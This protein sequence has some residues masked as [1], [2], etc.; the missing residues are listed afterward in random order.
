HDTARWRHRAEPRRFETTED[1]IPAAVVDQ[2]LNVG[3]APVWGK[4]W[5]AGHHSIS[6]IA[7]LRPEPTPMV[8]TRSP[9]L[10]E[11]SSRA[12][13]M[14]RAAGPILPSEGKVVGIFL[15]SIPADLMIASVCICDTWW[16]M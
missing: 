16:V 8:S 14:G 3:N 1:P 4:S 10:R 2:V 15:R 5:G 9:T 13:V 7:T 11:S 6:S 12:S